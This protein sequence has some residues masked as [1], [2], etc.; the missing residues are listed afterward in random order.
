MSETAERYR[1]LADQFTAKVQAVPADAWSNRTPCE[2]WTVRQLVGHMVDTSRMF[3]GFV[4]LELP[5]A[6]TVDDDPVTAWTSARDAVQAGLDDPEVAGRTYQGQFG[7]S[8]FEEG[9]GK[10][11]CIDLVVHGWDLARATGQDEHIDPAAAREV[12]EALLPMDETM[13]APGAFGPKVDVP[14]GADDQTRMLA[15]L[16]RQP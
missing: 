9:V 14:D 5:P 13:R 11:V 8:T 16:G 2:D 1:T 10:W 6:P 15:F 3:L 4:G 12:Y 7:T